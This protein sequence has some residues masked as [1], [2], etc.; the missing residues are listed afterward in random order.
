MGEVFFLDRI[1]LP[2]YG[3]QCGLH[4]DGI[5][6]NHGI[7]QQI[8]TSRLVG[9]PFLIFLTYHP[10]ACEEE[11]LP[12]IMKLLAFVELR[13]DTSAQGV[14]FE[15]AQHENRLHEASVLL[16]KLGE[17]PLARIGLQAANEERSRHIT[18]FQ[19][20]GDTREVVPFLQSPG[21][22][23]TPH[24]PGIQPRVNRGISGKLVQLPVT[25]VAQARRK[26]HAQQVEEA[27][28]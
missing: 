11:K 8:Q 1:P 25:N 17:L 9:L 3:I 23:N 20:T 14:I 28:H 10:F 7:G 27:K 13:M 26:L 15:V 12:E 24:E 16:E 22:I 5:P 4:V 21:Q 6:N 18:A 19:R 2:S